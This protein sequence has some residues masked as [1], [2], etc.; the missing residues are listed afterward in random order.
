[1]IILH[2]DVNSA[3]LS[4]TA[5][6]LLEKG[7]ETDIRTIP[8]IIGGDSS[9]RHGIVLAKS[10]PA[11]K[12]GIKTADPI[13][14][15][16]KKCPTLHIESPDF[17]IYKKASKSFIDYL[18][19]FTPDIEQVSIDECYLDY[20]PIMHKYG[21]PLEFANKI[22]TEIKSFFGF[23]VNVGISDKKVLAKMASDFEKPD[24]IHTLYSYEIQ[25][26]MWS[27][28]I[29]DLFMC[30]KSSTKALYNLGIKTI[31]DL[32]QSD[33]SII[34]SNL[35]SIGLLLHNF[36]NGID[37]SV[38]ETVHE[39]RKGLG[40]ATTLSHDVI[41]REEAIPILR[42]LSNKI[43]YDLRKEGMKGPLITVE[44]KYSDF[45]KHS[46]QHN[47]NVMTNSSDLIFN[48]AVKLFD[49]LWDQSPIRLIGI[50]ISKLQTEDEP[51]QLSIF[52]F[53]DSDEHNPKFDKLDKALDSMRLK[54][55][56]DAIKKGF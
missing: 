23:T 50:R 30:G 56:K 3:F 8:A 1:M 16:M 12:L 39:Q 4:W 46:Q 2:I 7:Y 36:A 17:N 27:L 15:A 34:E 49:T 44:L 32:A 25:E 42:E 24:K 45:T 19:S 33:A 11:G 37:D 10:I 9:L 41:N 51:V 38:I 55:G 47:L 22:K 5:V 28:P 21:D 26:K 54:Y 6:D 35:K 40:H 31:G 53:Q 48:S 18:H 43:S 20:T 29:S 14:S 13:A 52:D